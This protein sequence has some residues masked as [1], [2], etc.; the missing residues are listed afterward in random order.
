MPQD[1]D[2]EAEAERVTALLCTTDNRST[3]ICSP[4]RR[5]FRKLRLLFQTPAIVFEQMYT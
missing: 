1:Q 2:A 5:S 3:D 4:N